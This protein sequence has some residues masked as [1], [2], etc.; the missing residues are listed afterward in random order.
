MWGTAG[1]RLFPE[2]GLAATLHL[3][4]RDRGFSLAQL[5]TTQQVNSYITLE[6]KGK[7]TVRG[8]MMKILMRDGCGASEINTQLAATLMKWDS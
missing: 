7:R 3:H 6:H 2:I 4:C 1:A 8:Q 5:K